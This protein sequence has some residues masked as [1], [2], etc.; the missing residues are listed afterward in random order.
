[1]H[2]APELKTIYVEDE[3]TYCRMLQDA[4][5]TSGGFH[6]LGDFPSAEEGLDY[7]RDHDV[8]LV[9]IDIELRGERNGLW[10]ADQLKDLPV[11]L[12]F[13]TSHTAYALQAF[14]LCALDYLVK[15]VS[16]TDI[17]GMME[18]MNAK[19]STPL[20]REQIEELLHFYVSGKPAPKRLFINVVGEIIVVQ[21]SEVLYLTSVDR[22]T[23]IQM[24]DGTKHVSSKHLKVYLDALSGSQ[25]FVRIHRS[26]VV[27]KNYVRSIIRDGKLNQYYVQMTNGQKLEMSGLKK[28]E[29]IEELKR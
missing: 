18:R 3:P 28:N 26:S 16:A 5:T 8:D 2:S 22:Y 14:E 4:L 21:L 25:D 9:F 13:L 6:Y 12:V 17:T 7:V 1:M 15:P 29:I 24:A 11:A 27:N 10:L 23:S 19:R 20:F